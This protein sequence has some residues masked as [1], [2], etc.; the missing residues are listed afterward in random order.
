MK[1]V[2]LTLFKRVLTD[3]SAIQCCLLQVDSL[4]TRM[5]RGRALRFRVLRSFFFLGDG[6][7][8]IARNQSH[9]RKIVDISRL[10]I[11]NEN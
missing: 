10:L 1:I 6:S 9:P 8:K 7:A 5:Q 11:E 2:K 4:S 3:V